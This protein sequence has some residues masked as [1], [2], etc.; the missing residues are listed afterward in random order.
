MATVKLETNDVMPVIITVLNYMSA[1]ITTSMF[2][3]ALEDQFSDLK[4]LVDPEKMD[5]AMSDMTGKLDDP[6]SLILK[7]LSEEIMSLY[8]RLAMI[9]NI[10]LI[11]TFTDER[12]SA[13][14][15]NVYCSRTF[16][17]DGITP[18]PK[19]SLD[20]FL[21]S[22]P[23]IV[24]QLQELVVSK[25][26]DPEELKDWINLNRAHFEGFQYA[27]IPVIRDLGELALSIYDYH[28]K[29]WEMPDKNDDY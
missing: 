27:T 21:Y 9:H 22:L 6:L 1:H 17:T 5:Q 14:S 20:V 29:V 4:G 18:D 19:V 11:E 7:E 26:F 28:D 3:L 16:Y 25:E 15:A 8:S 10:D 2:K 12:L 23:V 13:L 24:D